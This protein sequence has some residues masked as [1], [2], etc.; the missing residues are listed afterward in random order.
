[1]AIASCRALLLQT[2]VYARSFAR[3]K[4]GNNNAARMAMTAMTTKSSIKVNARLPFR[5][6]RVVEG[7]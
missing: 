6:S 7:P 3:L 2:V 5:W 1:M 4:A